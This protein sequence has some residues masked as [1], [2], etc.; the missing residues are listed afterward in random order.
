MS[1]ADAVRERLHRLR[2]R[3]RGDTD[4]EE[5]ETSPWRRYGSLVQMAVVVAAA[6]GGAIAST[7]STALDSGSRV[8]RSGGPALLDALWPVLL[9]VTL[10]AVV[11]CVVVVVLGIRNV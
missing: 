3:F 2:E 5:T 7:A 8:V 1:P 6:F 9:G 11:V 10:V 4:D